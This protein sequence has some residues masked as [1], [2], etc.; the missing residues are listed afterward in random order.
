MVDCCLNVST[1]CEINIHHKPV[2]V[3][4]MRVSYLEEKINFILFLYSTS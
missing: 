2:F 1:D 3:E 4:Y